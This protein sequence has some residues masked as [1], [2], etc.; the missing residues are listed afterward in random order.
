LKPPGA[1]ESRWIEI[2]VTLDA[3]AHEALGAF[4]FD[5]GCDGIVTQSF[6]DATLKAYL[7]F[8][9]DLEDIRA[10]TDQFLQKLTDIF[11]EIGSPEV[12]LGTIED[13][14]WNRNWRRFFRPHKVTHELL[15]V[16]AWETVPDSQETRVIRID[17][18]P[19]FGTGK[20]PTTQMCL[21]AM[22][23]LPVGSQWTL[24]DVGTG[25]GILSLYG[26]ILGAHRIVALDIDPEAIRWAERNAALN[27]RKGTILFS[28]TPLDE[29]EDGFTVVTANLIL[30][31][32]L[33]LLPHLSRVIEKEGWLILSG[34][35]QDQVSTI[36]KVLPK[37]DLMKDGILALEEWT[38]LIARRMR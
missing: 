24:L 8:K 12:S 11:P 18:G 10:R 16:P 6:Q 5:L 2:S 36:E 19:A 21:Q 37:Y 38:C 13:R 7:P 31:T 33:D 4:F 3:V 25:S 20:H 27:R 17:P 23:D 1:V 9:E 32:I 34:I 29:I 15:I 35:L 22:E 30:S 28:L 26:V 14:D